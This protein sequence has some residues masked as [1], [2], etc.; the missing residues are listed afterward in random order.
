M[1]TK[2]GEPSGKDIGIVVELP[3]SPYNASPETWW[4]IVRSKSEI[5]RQDCQ[6]PERAKDTVSAG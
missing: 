1:D 3:A 6:P 4:R 2:R 5:D